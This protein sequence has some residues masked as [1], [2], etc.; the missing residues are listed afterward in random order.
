MTDAYVA[1]GLLQPDLFLAG[2]M[3]LDRDAALAALR[4]VAEPLNLE[5]V[6]L[7]EGAY[8]I[9]NTKIGAAVSAMTIDRGLD[10]REFSLFAYGA[11][12]P[13]HS[14]AVARELGIG[15]VIVPYFPGGFSAYGMT[16]SRSRVEHSRSVMTLMAGFSAAEWKAEL[17]ALAERCRADLD[18]QGIDGEDVTLEFV[19][20]GM[21]AGQG[22][23]NRLVLP[24]G[25]L[26]A[27]ALERVAADFHD[28]YESRF[29]Y[30][31]PEIPIMVTSLAVVGY[32]PIPPVTLPDVPT[33][34]EGGP[35]RAVIHRATLHLDGTATADAP[36]YDRNLLA[37][38][39]EIA[40]AA[41][42][43]DKL[44][45]IV[46]NPGAV[47]HVESHGTLRIEV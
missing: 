23:D 15:E 18:R 25:E 19:Y 16:A 36:F 8:A 14:V 43:D 11:A 27:A 2:Q 28:F 9:A 39:D 6:A 33:A 35:E 46:I 30:R 12:G 26:D 44:G 1:M 21:Y 22:S 29:G 34:G 31:A 4:R 42:I 38:G 32:G 7:A 13:M 45:T 20:Y 40:G 47:A 17:A 24:G 37:E 10:P 41:V 3:E 5:P